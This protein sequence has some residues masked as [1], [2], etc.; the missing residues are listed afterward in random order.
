M[1][2]EINNLLEQFSELGL[3]EDVAE[4]FL[5]NMINK[6][7]DLNDIINDKAI[8]HYVCIFGFEKALEILIEKGVKLELEDKNKLR[9][10]HYACKFGHPHIV[11]LLIENKVDINCTDIPGPRP[12]HYACGNGCIDIVKLLIDNGGVLNFKN[13]LYTPLQIA[14]QYGYSEIVKLLL[15]MEESIEEKDNSDSSDDEEDTNKMRFF[16][17]RDNETGK[18]GGRFTGCTSKQAASKVFTKMLQYIENNNEETPLGTLTII[19]KEST[20]GSYGK[21]YAYEGYREELEEPIIRYIID[22][23]TGESNAIKYKYRNS[24]K[25]IPIPDNLR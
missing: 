10:I 23:E 4:G 24:I 25:K 16:K 12:I 22:L 3:T 11:K 8:I 14:S 6:G 1:D 13:D 2:N 9:P 18:F 21:V 20:R 15:K 17:A 5:I 7:N 19:M